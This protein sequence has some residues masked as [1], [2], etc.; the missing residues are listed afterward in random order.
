MGQA[1]EEGEEEEGEFLAAADSNAEDDNDEHFAADEAPDEEFEGGYGE[2]NS[3][4]T[5]A[6]VALGIVPG[7]PLCRKEL[8]SLVAAMGELDVR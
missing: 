3:Q 6:D 8:E 2:L 1:D 7:P 4:L 5:S